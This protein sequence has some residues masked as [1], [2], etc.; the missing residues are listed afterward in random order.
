MNIKCTLDKKLPNAYPIPT[1]DHEDRRLAQFSS[2]NSPLE[3]DLEEH[4]YLYY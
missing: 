2:Q 1:I 3:S 4:P